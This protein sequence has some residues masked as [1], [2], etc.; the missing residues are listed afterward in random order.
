MSDSNEVKAMTLAKDPS[1]IF[2][3]K[4]VSFLD[5]LSEDEA[6]YLV[7]FELTDDSSPDFVDKADLPALC[8]NR[9]KSLAFDAMF[10]YGFEIDRPVGISNFFKGNLLEMICLEKP[11]APSQ[12]KLFDTAMD[13]GGKDILFHFD[14]FDPNL[15][16][17]ERKST[18]ILLLCFSKERYDLTR[19]A[20]NRF[21]SDILD[22]ISGHMVL[23]AGHASAAMLN[24][25]QG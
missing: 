22:N 12:D 19:S 8:A 20:V 13:N 5:S 10:K 6:R 2:G 14:E 7:N 1:D 18:S 16:P 17:W 15:Q 25:G 21:G 9:G 11:E 24:K 23:G 4:L 3:V